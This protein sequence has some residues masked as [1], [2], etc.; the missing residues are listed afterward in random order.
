MLIAPTS[1]VIYILF[2]SIEASKDLTSADK[3]FLLVSIIG[4][5]LIALIEEIDNASGKVT[6]LEIITSDPLAGAR[7]L[8]IATF[9]PNLLE[10]PNLFI[11]VKLKFFKYSIIESSTTPNLIK[12][13]INY[14]KSKKP[15]P[16]LQIT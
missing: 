1:P 2:G 11:L 9:V 4:M 13:Q 14:L 10:P 6:A 12:L 15:S 8:I 3:L 5:P 16:N 7:S